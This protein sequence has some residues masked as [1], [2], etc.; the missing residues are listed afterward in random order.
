LALEITERGAIDPRVTG[1]AV[2]EL[3]AAGHQ[4]Y[5]DD[6]GTGYS[7]LSYLETLHVDG[8]KIDKA[9]VDAVGADAATS[10]VIGH[11]ID[12]ARTL[13][14]AVVAEGVETGAQ[15]DFL[16]ERGVPLAQGWLYGKAVARVEFE[17]LVART[18]LAPPAL[19]TA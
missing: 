10:G 1:S 9:F 18:T 12:M 8:I 13:H 3:R 19:A 16:R 11:I 4:I 17:R 5:I 15:A 2:A 14:L 7:N 6:F